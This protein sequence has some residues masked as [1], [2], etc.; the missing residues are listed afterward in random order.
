MLHVELLL[1][2]ELCIGLCMVS[3]G[4]MFYFALRTV[5]DPVEVSACMVSSTRD[6]TPDDPGGRAVTKTDQCSVLP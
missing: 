3:A 2:W 6:R 1:F 5:K 4:C